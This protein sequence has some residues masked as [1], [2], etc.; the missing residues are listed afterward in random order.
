MKLIAPA[1]ERERGQVDAEDPEVLPDGRAVVVSRERR[2]GRPARARR[3]AV[4]AEA[5][6]DDEPAQEEEPERERVQPRERHVAR[7]DHERHEVVPEAGEDRHDEEEDHRRPVDREEL[8][9]A[10]A[11]D[12]VLLGLA[13]LEAHEEAMI[14]P[15][16]K[17][18][19][20]ETM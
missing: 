13:E 15:A 4:D 16:K 9:V 1:S 14:P 17:K 8:V 5:R 10:V 7:A 19:K 3:A 6:E 18:T 11:R 20:A 12:D 2:V